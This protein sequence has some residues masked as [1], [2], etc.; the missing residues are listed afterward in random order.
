MPTVSEHAASLVL[1]ECRKH[2]PRACLSSVL[3][4]EH[5]HTIVRVRAPE[6]MRSAKDLLRCLNELWPLTKTSLVHNCIDATHNVEVVVPH[7]RDEWLYAVS[8]AMSTPIA[9]RSRQMA[10]WLLGLGVLL[11]A[12]EMCL[13]LRF[14]SSAAAT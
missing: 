3:R 13:T 4:D 1:R 5:G 14:S 10:A 11:Y 8:H 9:L 12:V 2:D 7:Q 6:E